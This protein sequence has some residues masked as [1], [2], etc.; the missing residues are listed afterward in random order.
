MNKPLSRNR[1]LAAAVALADAHGLAKLSMRKL[2]TELG[3]E[4]MS[5][6]HHVKNKDDILDG[7][8]D[9]VFREI[10][11]PEP[12]DPWR[13]AMRYRAISA[14]TALGRH[15]WAVGLLDSRATPGTATLRHHDAVLACLRHGGFSVVMAAHAFSLIDSY[16]YGFVL[17]EQ[18]LPFRTPEEL[19]AVATGI[20]EEMG[21]QF[22]HVAEMTV[23]HA[24]QPGYDPAAEFLW[25][26][27]LLLDGL[28][29]R[30]T[31]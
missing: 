3:V 14:R 4:A 21:P 17:Q 28:A 13:A 8:V 22:P 7:M 11:L 12:T 9:T 31:P 10:E 5:L 19:A 16:V 25:G 2:A 15:R 27:D 30:V 6:Y 24:L 26:L 23:E 1:V 18:A 20:L 29:R